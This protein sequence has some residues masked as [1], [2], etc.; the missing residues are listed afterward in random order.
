[1]LESTSSTSIHVKDICFRQSINEILEMIKIF[2]SC[3][4]HL[5]VEH[6]GIL[7]EW[8]VVKNLW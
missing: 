4:K 5:T 8:L 3:T 7:K 2:D 6:I 1:M